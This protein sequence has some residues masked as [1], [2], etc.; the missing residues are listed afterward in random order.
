MLL[1]PDVTELTGLKG[2][3]L[4]DV[5][6]NL[7]IGQTSQGARRYFNDIEAAVLVL[8]TRLGAQGMRRGET[9]IVAEEAKPELVRLLRNPASARRW[10]F[11]HLNDDGLDGRGCGR[12]RQPRTLRRRWRE[13]VRRDQPAQHRA[14]R[15]R[16]WQAAGEAVEVRGVGRAGGA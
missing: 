12:Y 1:S 11:A 4:H 7:G 14:R 9:L 8:A 6:R 16:G 2:R 13:W 3:M 10:L 15:P 5:C